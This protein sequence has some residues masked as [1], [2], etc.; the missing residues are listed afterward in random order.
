MAAS[1]VPSPPQYALAAAKSETNASHLGPQIPVTGMDVT[2]DRANNSPTAVVDPLDSRFLALANRLDAPD[3]SCALHVSDDRGKSWSPVVPVPT[4]P[5]E[6]EKCYGP[7]VAIDRRGRIDFLFLGLTGSGNLPVGIYLTH[8]DDRG[9]TFAAPRRI[10]DGVNFAARM[11]ID[12]TLG[13]RGRLH[14][15]WL[16]AGEPPGLGSLGTSDNPIMAFHSDDGGGTFSNPV[17]VSDPVRHRVVAPSLAVGP[18]HTVYVAYYDLLDDARDYQ[19]LDGPVWDGPWQLVLATIGPGDGHV[20]LRSVVEPSVTPHERV[21][22][23]FTMPPAALAVRGSKVCLGWTDARLG[24]ADVMVR[25]SHDGGQRWS[26][27]V[28]V[29]HDPPASG[30]WQ[31]LPAVGI[32]P[33]GRVDVV[34]Y[35]RRDDPQNVLNNVSYSFSTDLGRT[36]SGRLKLTPTGSS[37]SL[38]GQQY[39]VPSAG[40]R[41]DFGFRFALLSRGGDLF[42]AWADTHLSAP[43]TM[44]Q[45]VIGTVV[46]PP[47]PSRNW[48]LL[49][50]IALMGAALVA[51]IASLRHRVRLRQSQIVE[52]GVL[53]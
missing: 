28:R 3:Y 17:R 15:V 20:G 48:L 18:D 7:E 4:L 6:V 40:D 22:V 35:D 37:S 23:I 2:A 24:D 27:A 29:N 34:Y 39:A 51:L 52:P 38:I 19:G 42:T 44:A 26:E 41:Y 21:M 8:S 14:V 46:H 33:H 53:Q 47:R 9:R 49:V 10:V 50:W 25:C 32:S 36:F 45:D 12:P 43:G 11:A 16:H 13:T 5:P 1:I 30:L 31:Y